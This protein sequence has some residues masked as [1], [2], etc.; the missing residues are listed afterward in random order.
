[1]SIQVSFADNVTQKL[2]AT[3]ASKLPYAQELKFAVAFVSSSGLALI[4]PYLRQCLERSG[5]AEFLVGLDLLTTEPKALKILHEMSQAG[6]PITCFCYSDPSRPSASIYHPKLYLTAT[7]DE[8]TIVIG[9]SNLTKGGLKDNVEI[10]A[11]VQAN[12][13]DEIVSDIYAVYNSLKFQQ[14]RVEPDAEFINLYEA[15]HHRAKRRSSEALRDSETK[16]L[17]QRFNDKIGT[18]RR[19][20]PTAGDLFGWQKIVFERLPTGTFK[21][22]DLY[23]FEREFQRYYP[24]N[25]N[26]KAK[27]RQILQQLRDLG[28]IEHPATNQW[29]GKQ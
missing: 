27:I 6:L 13:G 20:K 11:V 29:E 17:M 7:E 22:S 10:N 2:L 18:L 12:R 5:Q 28:L 26:I 3:L 14:P 15:L 16:E 21:T 25:Q 4:E 9:S 24:Q 8:A 23:D 1:M 19:P